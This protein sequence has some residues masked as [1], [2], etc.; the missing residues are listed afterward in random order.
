[1]IVATPLH[2]WLALSPHGYGHAGM[3]A[4]VIAELRRRHPD[5]RLTIQTTLPDHFLQSRFGAY[6]KVPVI[7]DFGFR[8]ISASQVDVEASRHAY[9]ELIDHLSEYRDAEAALIQA[10]KPDVILANVPFITMAA[11]QL[12]GVPVIGFSS[13]NW[14]DLYRDI[15]PQTAET[16]VVLNRMLECYESAVCFLQTTPAQPMTLS[17]LKR[18]GPVGMTGQERKV[19]LRQ[20][21]QIGA[22]VK[23]GL[24]AFGGMDRGLDVTTWPELSGWFWLLS[25][26]S[27]GQ[28]SDMVNWEKA[29]MSFSDLLA[30]VDVVVTK[31]GYGTFVEAA[32]VGTPILYE[33]RPYWPEAPE[34][35]K[36]ISAN[37]RSFPLSVEDM[38]GSKLESSL[39]TLF[40][41]PYQSLSCAS[42]IADVADEVERQAGLC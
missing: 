18:V 17:R 21:L 41:M 23:I 20:R 29:E 28:R 38:L 35:E 39:H 2:L 26:E 9:A 12:A 3:S 27:Q 30:S 32:L 15:I 8:M 31:S 37:N 6:E 36:W 11:G 1:M 25:K 7:H 22:Q 13:L 10:A 34:L 16:A 42:G 4:P 33:P 5:M 40:S 14:A 24:I 19:E